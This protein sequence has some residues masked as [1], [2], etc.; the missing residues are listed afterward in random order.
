MKSQGVKHRLV[1]SAMEEHRQKLEDSHRKLAE[2]MRNS[3]HDVRTQVTRESRAVE[4]ARADEEATTHEQAK[5]RGWADSTARGGGQHTSQRD[6]GRHEGSQPAKPRQSSTNARQATD[7]PLSGAIGVEQ[8]PSPVR[9]NS[10]DGRYR[11]EPA[12]MGR[13][14]TAPFSAMVQI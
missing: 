12:A 10:H 9:G 11:R 1:M 2:E 8:P 14:Q 6:T 5:D 4:D 3:L 7:T 13:A